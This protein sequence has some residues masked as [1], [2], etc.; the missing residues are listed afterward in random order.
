MG[1]IMNHFS[2]LGL[3]VKYLPLKCLIR[4]GGKKRGKKARG[5]GRIL[6]TQTYNYI[7]KTFRRHCYPGV[8]DEEG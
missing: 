5:K 8:I 2:N 7:H 4:E 6:P 3:S 1:V